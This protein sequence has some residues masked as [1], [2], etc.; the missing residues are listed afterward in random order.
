M[1]EYKDLICSREYL[2]LLQRLQLA[3]LS[4]L[5]AEG[6]GAQTLIM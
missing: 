1:R 6:D 4:Y 2:Y 5:T 3:D